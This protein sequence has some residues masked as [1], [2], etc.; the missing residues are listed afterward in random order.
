[1]PKLPD[2]KARDVCTQTFSAPDDL[3][4]RNNWRLGFGKFAVGDVHV[5][6]TDAARRNAD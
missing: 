5:G 2:A 1:M 6:P 4:T 3:V